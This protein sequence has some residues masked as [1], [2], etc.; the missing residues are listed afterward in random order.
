MDNGGKLIAGWLSA[1]YLWCALFEFQVA[2]RY[3]SKFMTTC[4]LLAKEVQQR[5]AYSGT[6]MLSRLITSLALPTLYEERGE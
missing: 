4:F 2:G 6:C 3:L 1:H 5:W